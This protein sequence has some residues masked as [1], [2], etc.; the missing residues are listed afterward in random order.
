L[1]VALRASAVALASAFLFSSHVANPAVAGGETRTLSFYNLHTEESDS[2]TYMVN[3]SYDAAALDKL[4]WFLRD[5][6]INESIKMDPKLFDILWQVYQESGSNEPID[7][8]SAYRSPQTNAMLRMRSRQVAEHSQHMEGRAIDAHFRDISV[9]KVRD[10][11]MRMESGGVGFY[12]VG[13]TPW[14]HV[15]SGSIR[16][17]PRMNR[18]S[19]ARIFPDGKTVFIPSDGQPMA[20]FEEARAEIEAR[21]GSVQTAGAEFNLFTWLFSNHNGGAD[22]AE[23]S[24]PNSVNLQGK[25]VVA[26]A[27]KPVATPAPAVEVAAADPAVKSDAVADAPDAPVAPL[28]PK[29]PTDLTLAY[30]DMPTPPSRPKDL[31]PLD[32]HEDLIRGLL[33]QADLPP[34]ITRGIVV[35]PPKR[36]LALAA[37][38]PSGDN[39][40]SVAKLAR[41]ATLFAALPLPP[42]RPAKLDP[43]VTASVAS[44]L[45]SFGPMAAETDVSAFGAL[46]PAAYASSPAEAALS[47]ALKRAAP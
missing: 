38:P 23:E 37:L 35:A 26:K 16:Y 9:A 14:V 45:R 44:E 29:R 21:G 17:W 8:L 43:V 1:R 11:A 30:A 39:A 22:D 4:N 24:G 32:P 15:D 47:A 10:I 12:P 20:K 19:L 18:D 40:E 34:A 6:R 7:V 41:A 25:Q 31:A 2:F 3:G 27:E 46:A 5:W 42:K 36:A 28:P 33:A 13:N